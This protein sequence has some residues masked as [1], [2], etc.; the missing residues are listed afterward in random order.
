RDPVGNLMVIDLDLSRYDAIAARFEAERRQGVDLLKQGIQTRN[1]AF[2]RT[3]AQLARVAQASTAPIL[4][5]GPTGAGK[6][7]LASKIYE[8]RK[9][10]HLLRGPFVE[11]NCATLRGDQAMSTLFGHRRGAFTGAVTDRGGLL[12][13]ADGGLLFLDEIA[14]L[15]LDEQAMLLRAIEHGRFMPL[16]T[17]KEVESS[18]QLIAGTNADLRKRSRDGRFRDDLLARIDLWT[19]ELPGLRERP[20][21]IEP[22]LDYELEAYGRRNRRLVRMSREARAAFL[23]YSLGPDALW[24]GNFR[25]LSGAVERM[26]TLS[27]GGRI[28]VSDVTEECRRLSRDWSVDG[29]NDRVTRILGADAAALLDRFDRVQLEDVL[30]VC[31]RS[32]SLSAAGRELFSESRKRRTSTNDSDRLRKYL[33]RFELTHADTRR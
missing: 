6:T 14:E 22:N 27:A 3:I 32:P 17:D 11:V 21:D 15:G 28:A 19:F 5:I 24:S 7:R 16:G 8:F 26:A 29:G 23:A 13:A 20:E 33:A 18:F 30:S 31:A 2:N 25:D 4:L 1:A 9:E 10:H 12:K